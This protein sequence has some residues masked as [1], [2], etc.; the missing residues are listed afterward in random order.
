METIKAFI[1]H[2]SGEAELGNLIK[3]HIDAAFIG[4]VDVYVSSDGTSI[5]VGDN[6]MN[7]VV[8]HLQ[9]ADI[10]IV[11][12][13]QHSLDR[14]WINLELGAALTRGKT[15][16]PLC[17]TDLLAA[18]LVR[19]PLSDFEALNASDPQGLKSLFTKLAD[20]LGSRVPE[21]DWARLVSEVRA[22]ESRYLAQ[23]QT[24]AQARLQ[25][26]SSEIADLTLAAPEVLCVSSVQFQTTVR[27]DLEM[28]HAAF[29]NQTHHEMITTSKELTDLMV[30]KHFDVIHVAA[31]VC[32]VSGDLVFSAVDPVTKQDLEKPRD[33]LSAEQFMAL[34]VESGASLVVLANNET[35]A[36][37]TK[38]LQVTSVVFALEP[39]ESKALAAWIASF[40]DFLAEGFSLRESC[41]KA[42]AQHQL[43][44]TLYPRL[45]MDMTVDG[46][47]QADYAQPRL[48][49]AGQLA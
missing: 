34:V 17:H 26:R 49:S 38:L 19:R 36:L 24:I 39:I 6:W 18:Q 9:Q 2:A 33:E 20:A 37:V 14:P 47:P 13:S 43:P 29:P 40:Y 32:P 28:I 1:S 31:F 42:F 44:M 45:S 30:R 46:G 7:S 3:T 21:I 8:S 16:I 48:E 12:C 10:F 5:A 25:N 11:L 22:F 4:M 27:E 15:I 35:L 41:R 23:K